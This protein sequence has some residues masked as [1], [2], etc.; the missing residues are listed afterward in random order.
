MPSPTRPT[1]RLA[2]PSERRGGEGDA[3]PADRL[4]SLTLRLP[5]EP[6][7]V[8]VARHLARHLLQALGTADRVADD[9]E[10]GVGEACANAVQHAWRGT[11]FDLAI[12]V[13]GPVCTVRVI[14]EGPGFD[15][16]GVAPVSVSAEG[17][18]GL[19]LMR[20]VAD[21]LDV[22]SRQEHGTIVRLVKR[23]EPAPAAA[24]RPLGPPA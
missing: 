24:S 4:H 17:G 14:D 11:A 8:P 19:A 18:R 16:D 12:T 21:E 13:D 3:R 7:S 22:V 9:V 15:P 23:L 10:T 5:R 6:A 1:D 2:A 20:A